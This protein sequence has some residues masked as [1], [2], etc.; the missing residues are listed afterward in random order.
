MAKQDGNVQ[1]SVAI[2][3]GDGDG[4]TVV[5]QVLDHVTKAVACSDVQKRLAALPL[6]V[7]VLACPHALLCILGGSREGAG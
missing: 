1:R 6:C 7:E 4:S 2:F 3:I 5:E